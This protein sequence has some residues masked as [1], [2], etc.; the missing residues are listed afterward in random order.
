[1]KNPLVSVVIVNYN[2]KELTLNC[3]KSLSKITY[4]NIQIIVIDNNSEDDSAKV[5]ASEY[6]KIKLVRN[7]ENTGFTGG[8]N[9]GL[10]YTDGEYI[11]LLN[12][13]TVVTPNFIEPLVEDFLSQKDLGVVQSKMFVMDEPSLL[14]NVVSFQTLTGFLFHQG[15]LDTDKPDYQRFLYSFSAKGACMMID[16]KVLDLGLF[17]EEYFAYFEE[18]DL[19]WRVWLMGFKVGFEP[20]SIIYHKMGATSSKMNSSFVHYHS[21]KNRIRTIIK[22]A[23]CKTLLWM[24]PIHVIICLSLAGYFFIIRSDGAKSVIKALWWNITHI[25]KTMSL[26]KKIQAS[27][28]MT[29]NQIFKIV[30]KNPSLSFY[31][32]HL[33]L[34]R[35]NLAK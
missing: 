21:F 32:N 25:A 31:L 15:Y 28:K 16:R 4:P 14:D 26:R 22:N 11:L 33:S 7:K 24:L 34:V 10:K 6:P 3:L 23:E 29:D 20:R 13:D 18:T 2:Q 35:E 1:M 27:R 30:M 19:C 12:N 5:I 8:N 9:E 17:D